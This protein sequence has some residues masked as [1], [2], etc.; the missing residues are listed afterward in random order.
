MKVK[1]AHNSQAMELWVWAGIFPSDQEATLSFCLCC[2]EGSHSSM[3]PTDEGVV[4][5]VPT[6]YFSFL[7]PFS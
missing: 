4:I 6:P 1:E 2:T 7:V 5:T 3:P